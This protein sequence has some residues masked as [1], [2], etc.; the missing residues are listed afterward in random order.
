MS[1]TFE[2]RERKTREFI[3]GIPFSELVIFFGE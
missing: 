3:F 2:E 1:E